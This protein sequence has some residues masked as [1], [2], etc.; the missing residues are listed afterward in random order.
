MNQLNCYVY[1]RNPLFASAYPFQT[2]NTPFKIDIINTYIIEIRWNQIV[3][4]V[5]IDAGLIR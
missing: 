1:N 5:L 3:Y 4:T 2:K